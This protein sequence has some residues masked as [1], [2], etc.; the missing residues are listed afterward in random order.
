MFVNTAL[1]SLK[2]GI[3]ATKLEKTSGFYLKAGTDYDEDYGI[4]RLKLFP[5]GTRRQVLAAISRFDFI[6][7]E[8]TEEERERLAVNILKVARKF[9]INT[10]NFRKRV[11]KN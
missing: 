3:D 10:S 4:P 2:Y 11:F 8:I 1:A 7:V 6:T 5:L 9:N